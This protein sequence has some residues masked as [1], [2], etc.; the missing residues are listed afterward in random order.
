MAIRLRQEVRELIRS[1]LAEGISPGQIAAELGVNRTTVATYNRYG[2]RAIDRR[3]QRRRVR[4]LEAQG[5]DFDAIAE[6]L[7][8]HPG[9]ARLY[10]KNPRPKFGHYSD[11][12]P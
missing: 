9:T 12:L 3:A 6:I 2:C 7:K 1:K 8:I 4:E 5:H 11:L 10:S